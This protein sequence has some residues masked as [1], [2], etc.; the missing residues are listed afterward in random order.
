MQK[1]IEMISILDV[2]GAVRTG[3]Q[4][5]IEINE[6]EW[7][8]GTDLVHKPLKFLNLYLKSNSKSHIDVQ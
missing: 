1:D 3:D 5:L 8:T 7:L 6:R 2:W 4:Y